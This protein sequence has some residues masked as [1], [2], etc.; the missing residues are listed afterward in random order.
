MWNPTTSLV[1]WGTIS[2]FLSIGNRKRVLEGKEVK[3]ALDLL[4]P[5]RVSGDEVGF[6]YPP[7]QGGD[8]LA[9]ID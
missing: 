9:K 4:E 2:S 7:E 5:D 8:L 3:I 6:L 1:I